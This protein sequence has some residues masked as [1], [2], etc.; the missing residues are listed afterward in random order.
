MSRGYIEILSPN[1]LS[2]NPL[3]SCLGP[4][5]HTRVTFIPFFVSRPLNR[6]PLLPP[7][8]LPLL[9]KFG[10]QDGRWH[11]PSFGRGII[12]RLVR[13]IELLCRMSYA[14]SATEKIQIIG[15]F[16]FF[17]SPPFRPPFPSPSSYRAPQISLDLSES[18]NRIGERRFLVNFYHLC[19]R[20]G[21][22]RGTFFA[23]SYLQC[24]Y[25]VWSEAQTP[26][27]CLIFR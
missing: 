23:I 15:L 27:V 26:P 5:T 12:L 9:T 14:R 20:S 25:I 16:F 4:W 7:S 8:L 21:N 10:W 1:F 2:R 19:P 13:T 22:G 3:R 24:P 17:S 18:W 6:T 11:P